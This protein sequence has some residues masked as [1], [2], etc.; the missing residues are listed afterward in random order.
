[1]DNPSVGHAENDCAA[2]PRIKVCG[3]VDDGRRAWEGAEEMTEE[4]MGGGKERGG[5]ERGRF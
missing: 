3:L 4:G 1:V 2:H 5:G